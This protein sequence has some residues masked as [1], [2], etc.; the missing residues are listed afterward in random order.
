MINQHDRRITFGIA[1]LTCVLSF[2][3]WTTAAAQERMAP[4]PADKM[5]DAQKKAAAD[6]TAARGNLSGPWAVLLRSPELVN[7]VRPLSDYLRFNSVLPPRLSEF[8]ILITAR[9]WAQQYEWNAHYPLALKGGLNPEVAKA[10]AEGRR[11]AKMAEDEEIA[12]DFCTELDSNHS[13]SDAT[14]ARALSKFGEQGIVEM[15]SL[16]GYYTLIAM[17]LNTARTP[18]PPGAT[19]GLARLPQ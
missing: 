3:V 2:S 13:V 7:R 8:D 17:V 14:Y 11:P 9:E 6:F 4:I 19:S 5:T 18:L 16:H 10:I 15:V 1:L 12:Y